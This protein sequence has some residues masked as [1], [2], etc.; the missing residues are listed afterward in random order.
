MA[1]DKGV[2]VLLTN[3]KLNVSKRLRK[4]GFY[5]QDDILPRSSN[6]QGGY[7]KSTGF[8]NIAVTVKSAPSRAYSLLASSGGSL[9]SVASKVNDK[10]KNVDWKNVEYPPTA[11]SFSWL[12]VLIGLALVISGMLHMRDYSQYT[13]FEC[14]GNECSYRLVLKLFAVIVVIVEKYL[15]NVL[16]FIRLTQ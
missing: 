11:V 3:F 7:G 2:S 15:Y 16:L 14:T 10:V 8:S 5:G 12:M 4:T 6:P 9:G 1:S 13:V